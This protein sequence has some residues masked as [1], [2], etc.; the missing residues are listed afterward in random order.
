MPSAD[1]LREFLAVIDEG[2]I[3][4]AARELV[5][6]RATLSR[7]LSEL[8]SE[9]GV[10]LMHR[11]TRA[12]V[13][14]P[15]G[16]ELHR[17]ARRVVAETEAAWDS[18]RQ[19]DDRP[20]GLLRVSIPDIRAVAPELFLGFAADYPDV[21]L[22]VSTDSR[23]VDLVAEGIDV[24]VRFGAVRDESLIVRRLWV[25][26]SMLVAAPQYLERRG[27]PTC[28]EDLADHDCITGF[29]GT[30]SAARRWPLV[31][32][33]H[34]AVTARFSST[35]MLLQVQAASAGLGIALAPTGAM[36]PLLDDGRLV[37]VLEGV[38]GIETPASLVF[39]DREFL[40]PRVRLFID[41]AV[42]HFEAKRIDGGRAE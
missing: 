2:S 27:V 5:I 41:R 32:G 23:H 38:V 40:P 7:R 37:S 29:A 35:S 21:Q 12:L 6:P 28:T 15:A 33:G 4:A 24:A 25:T 18:V 22:E 10:R 42:E 26:R 36:Q 34:V 1:R 17:R 13:L 9:L 3:S 31:A 19:L 39:V 20:R 11:R 8:E 16:E 14:T 30:T